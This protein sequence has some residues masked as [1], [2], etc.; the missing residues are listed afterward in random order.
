MALVANR[1]IARALKKPSAGIEHFRPSVIIIRIAAIIA[2]FIAGLEAITSNAAGP[3]EVPA[4]GD[5]ATESPARGEAVVWPAIFGVAPA[6]TAPPEPDRPG[7]ADRAQPRLE[8]AGVVSAGGAHW[9]IAS[10]E[11]R[12]LVLRNGDVIADGWQTDSITDDGIVLRKG[13]ERLALAAPASRRH[14]DG[15]LHADAAPKS[16]AEFQRPDPLPAPVMG[17]APPAAPAAPAAQAAPPPAEVARMLL[18]SGTF[19]LR[20]DGLQIDSV[21]EDGLFALAGIGAGDTI[22][23]INSHTMD[24]RDSLAAA[25]AD[26]G[27]TGEASFDISRNGRQEQVRIRIAD[28]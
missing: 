1:S 5:V 18:R 11:G 21:S 8:L 25:I 7:P 14:E 4:R 3:T 19:S 17:D 23:R 26:I 28:L 24:R 20:R 27:A 10:V 15:A 9:A 12:S 6:P 13:Q 16:E 22:L 2:V